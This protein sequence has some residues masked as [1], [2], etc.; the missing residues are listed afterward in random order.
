[1]KICY[2]FISYPIKLQE[3]KETKQPSSYSNYI[4]SF[5]SGTISG[6][7]GELFSSFQN[8]TAK[9]VLHE[10]KFYDEC[11]TS[12]VQQISKDF[13]KSALKRTKLFNNLSQTNP[14]LFGAATGVPMLI[15][16]RCFATPLEN[17]R[18][19]KK[20]SFDGFEHSIIKDAAY[21]SI[22]NG[23]DQYFEAIVYPKVLPRFNSFMTKKLV[24]AS[25]AGM[26]GGASYVLAWPY[27]TLID[28]QRI[29]E[30]FKLMAR[31]IPKVGIKKITY[32]LTK[33][34]VLKILN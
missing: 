29:D 10:A 15:L 32:S 6:F 13:T 2:H 8:R 26:I 11:V 25:C 17:L 12:G 14:L 31:M 3:E 33:P 16:T 9:A 18:K 28:R 23:L 5:I 1:M 34:E 24:E 4:S 7:A 21:H 22:K 20:C 30:A 19:N 27:K